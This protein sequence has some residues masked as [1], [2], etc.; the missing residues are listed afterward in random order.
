MKSIVFA[1]WVRVLTKSKICHP[2]GVIFATER[3][4][5]GVI[6]MLWGK[7][8]PL[9]D[10]LTLSSDL[11]KLCE[12]GVLKSYWERSPRWID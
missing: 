3:C 12:S 8:A 1:N 5:L 11:L 7:T 10:M 9:H 4:H 2:E 6:E